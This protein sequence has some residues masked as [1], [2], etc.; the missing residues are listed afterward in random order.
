MSDDIRMKIAIES[1]KTQKKMRDQFIK[2]FIETTNV[3]DLGE[4]AIGTL[5][6]VITVAYNKGAMDALAIS[7]TSQLATMEGGEDYDI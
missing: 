2:E 6:Y 1:A 5:K 3:E 7:A 4:E